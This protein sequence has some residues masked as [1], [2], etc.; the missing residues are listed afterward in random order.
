[1]CSHA[2][3]ALAA[4]ITGPRTFFVQ[5]FCL[6]FFGCKFLRKVCMPV[7]ANV[8]VSCVHPRH[9]CL[10]AH[11]LLFACACLLCVFCC[12]L[13]CSDFVCLHMIVAVFAWLVCAFISKHALCACC[14]RTRS[15]QF[16]SCAE[17]LC[18][19]HFQLYCAETPTYSLGGKSGKKTFQL[20]WFGLNR[21]KIVPIGYLDMNQLVSRISGL[22]S[23]FSF[24][25][26]IFA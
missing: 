5:V 21:K 14:S 20:A 2:R 16:I 3:F 8:F 15:R 22:F 11:F 10:V 24:S 1:M 18:F 13:A 19:A 9:A 4:F 26:I 7:R 12:L 17:A 25:I 6:R 23:Y